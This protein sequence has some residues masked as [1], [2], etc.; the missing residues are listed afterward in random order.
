MHEASLSIDTWIQWI[1]NWSIYSFMEM[2]HSDVRVQTKVLSRT[3]GPA[4]RAYTYWFIENYA[5]MSFDAWLPVHA[6][7]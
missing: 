5:R 1:S 4:G 7:N 6:R 2:A 3:Y